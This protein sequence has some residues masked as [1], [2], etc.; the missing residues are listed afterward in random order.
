MFFHTEA[1]ENKA[2]L[3]MNK[4]QSLGRWGET[5]DKRQRSSVQ[6]HPDKQHQD[7]GMK[8][9]GTEGQEDKGA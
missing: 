9:G 6:K 3:E 8:E 5:G 4:A 1:N 7:L 2:K